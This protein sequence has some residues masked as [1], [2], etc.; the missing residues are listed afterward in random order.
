LGQQAIPRSYRWHIFQNIAWLSLEEGTQMSVPYYEPTI[1][2][3]LLSRLNLFR[4]IR[5]HL[6]HSQVEPGYYL[7]FGVLNGDSMLEAYQTLRGF[8]ERYYGFD[9]FQGLP[10]LSDQDSKSRHLMPRWDQG[11]VRGDA[12]EGVRQSLIARGIPN[13]KLTLVPGYYEDALPSFDAGSLSKNGPCHVCLVDCDLYSSSKLVFKFIEPLLVTGTWLL[14]DDY[15]CY[16][17]APNH[18]QRKAFHEWIDR[19][20]RIGVSDWANFRGWGKAFIVYEK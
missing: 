2:G 18:G 17:G 11:R 9:S 3:D 14:L 10:A 19:S 15:W 1:H 13:D 5:E 20:N 16:R 12:V 4:F 6:F 7:E 8:T